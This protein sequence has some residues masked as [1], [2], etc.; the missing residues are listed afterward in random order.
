MAAIHIWQEDGDWYWD[1]AEDHGGFDR[2]VPSGPFAT[3]TNAYLDAS[4]LFGSAIDEDDVHY[5]SKPTHYPDE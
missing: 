5:G 4:S 3:E 2:C 1:D